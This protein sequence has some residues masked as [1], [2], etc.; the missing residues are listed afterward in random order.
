MISFSI[1]QR[2]LKEKLILSIVPFMIGIILFSSILSFM[3]SKKA[4]YNNTSTFLD[5]AVK[6]AALN[7]DE[8][9]KGDLRVLETISKI[10]NISSSTISWEEKKSILNLYKESEEY[11]RIGIADLNGNFE[12]TDGWKTNIKEDNYFKN[13]L[14]GI[15]VPCEPATTTGSYEFGMSVPI[16]NKANNKVIGVLISVK[17]GKVFQ[18]VIA[19]LEKD[20]SMKANVVNG[21]GTILATSNSEDLFKHANN[22]LVTDFSAN[23]DLS[24]SSQKSNDDEYLINDK[25][26]FVSLASLPTCNWSL[27][28][29]ANKSTL[30]SSLKTLGTSSILLIVICSI[31]IIFVVTRRTASITNPLNTIVKALKSIAKKDFTTEL[32][33]KYIQNTDEI[34]ELS[35]SISQTQVS[36]SEMISALQN[37]ALSIDAEAG[38][39]NTMSDEFTQTTSSISESIEEVAIGVTKQSSDVSII[40]NNLTNFKDKLNSNTHEIVNISCAINEMNDK[41]LNSNKDMNLFLHSFDDLSKNFT[42]LSHN[43][44][45]VK[46]SI[47]TVN[48]ITDLINNVADQ[49]NLL[50][51]NA[52]IE[53][54]RAGDAG[55]GFA[56][57][58]QEIR[59]LSEQTNNASKKISNLINDIIIKSEDMVQST[60]EVSNTLEREKLTVENSVEAFKEIST[61][62]VT[63]SPKINNITSQSKEITKI[64]ED[65]IDKINEFSDLSMT[66]AA[67]AEEISAA[68]HEMNASSSDIASTSNNLTSNTNEI[69]S[70]FNKFKI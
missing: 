18:D 13:S 51:L 44:S 49:T 45:D 69:I 63:I 7:I 11:K 2:K 59:S 29:D 17:E 30:L 53:A 15:S 25:K 70:E 32:D 26:S 42:T 20:I 6:N 12:S 5:M 16:M 60:I 62:I 27:L 21:Y 50:A 8:S 19:D 64:N 37:I 40:V 10:E 65:I 38:S 48:E 39:L 36:I 22:S 41:A 3:I 35:R 14:K 67:S 9:I 54:A 24:F 47:I 46:N 58:A 56:V 28:V 52:A 57:V 31:I 33:D 55:R 34:G 66:I 68:T 23:T 43:I 4:L 1:K 61:S